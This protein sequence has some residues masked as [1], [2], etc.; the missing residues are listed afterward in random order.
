MTETNVDANAST[1]KSNERYFVLKDLLD[2]TFKMPSAY[3]SRV[4][5]ARNRGRFWPRRERIRPIA[6][7]GE[8]LMMGFGGV[9]SGIGGLRPF[10][11]MTDNGGLVVHSN[12]GFKFTGLNALVDSMTDESYELL[13]LWLSNDAASALALIQDAFE[14]CVNEMVYI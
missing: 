5:W 1:D 12:D 6:Y 10:V 11:W 9:V 4:V 3:G 13:V 14:A 7:H 8:H 2:Y